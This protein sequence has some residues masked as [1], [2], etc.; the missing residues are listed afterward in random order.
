MTLVVS[1][2][3]MIG[4]VT[5]RPTQAPVSDSPTIGPTK[6]S[7]STF[8]TIAPTKDSVSSFPTIAPT[9][10]SF[11]SFPTIAPSSG[12]APSAA[13]TES[14]DGI[15]VPVTRFEVDYKTTGTVNDFQFGEAEKITLDYLRQFMEQQF[16]FNSMTDL[17]DFRGTLV[18]KDNAATIA[19]YDVT[20]IFSKGSIA[21]PSSEEADL[22][23]FAAFNQP[24][25]QELIKQLQALSAQNPFSQTNAVTYNP[26]K[27]RRWLVELSM[28]SGPRGL[29]MTLN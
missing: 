5:S 17:I 15:A 23:V 27:K 6:E 9:E 1:E 24:F 21:A 20:L 3:P 13:P 22:L 16:S 8:P 29:S 2:T 14:I 18:E 10:S 4:P 19:T 12:V 28:L 25:V 11:S 26:V 7:I